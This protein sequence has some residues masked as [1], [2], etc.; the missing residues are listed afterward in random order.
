MVTVADETG[1]LI[2]GPF[3]D[4][5]VHE[6]WWWERPNGAGDLGYNRPAVLRRCASIWGGRVKVIRQITHT[7]TTIH[8]DAPGGGTDAE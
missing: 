2:D 1:H 8:L 4:T 6:S 3:E 5:R 7:T